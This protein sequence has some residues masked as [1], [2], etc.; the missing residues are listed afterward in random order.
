MIEVH[1]TTAARPEPGNRDVIVTMGSKSRR[2]IVIDT[3]SEP[4]VMLS[5]CLMPRNAGTETLQRV[6][7]V[8]PS[9]AGRVRSATR[10]ETPSRLCLPHA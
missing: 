5:Q 10:N 7:Q 8:G 6:G 4:L 9:A 2:R 3:C 1:P